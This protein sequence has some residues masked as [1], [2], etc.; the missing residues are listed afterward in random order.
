MITRVVIDFTSGL[1]YLEY[2]F[3]II[4]YIKTTERF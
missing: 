4:L 3:I 2:I 1:T